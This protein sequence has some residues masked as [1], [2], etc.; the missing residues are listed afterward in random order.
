M[1]PHCGGAHGLRLRSRPQTLLVGDDGA[2][3]SFGFWIGVAFVLLGVTL[4][5]VVLNWIVGPVFP[6]LGLYLLPRL[7][8][9]KDAA[10]E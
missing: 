7:L 6:L 2:G 8:G 1:E 4:K 5:S 3:G 9:R 10:P